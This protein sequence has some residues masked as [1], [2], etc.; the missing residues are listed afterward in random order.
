[1]TTNDDEILVSFAVAGRAYLSLL[2][3]NLGT[4]SSIEMKPYEAK[5][6]KH[7]KGFSV[8]YRDVPLGE[9]RALLDDMRNVAEC[10]SGGDSESGE[11]SALWIAAE[12]IWHAIE[13]V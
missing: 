3:P 13:T 7:G 9:A 12:R 11:S 10:F 5:T 8:H 4:E 1:M 2:D 6:T